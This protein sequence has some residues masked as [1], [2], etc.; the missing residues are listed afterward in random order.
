MT[1]VARPGAPTPGYA[2]PPPGSVVGP[3]WEWSAWPGSGSAAKAAPGA[4]AR[5]RT[6]ARLLAPTRQLA[7]Y[8]RPPP[9]Y[10]VRP[11]IG[12]VARRARRVA[13]AGPQGDCCLP[14]LAPTSTGDASTEREGDVAGL[15]AH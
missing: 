15:L 3:Y 4:W 9:E 14:L 7:K 2:P 10:L 11:S 8:M 5:S 13:R 1:P 6:S 12:L